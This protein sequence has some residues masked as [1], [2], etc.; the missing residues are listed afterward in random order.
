MILRRTADNLAAILAQLG[1]DVDP[2]ML[3]DV[4]R[5]RIAHGHNPLP[6]DA[7]RALALLADSLI[8]EQQ[9]DGRAR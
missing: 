4:W 1:A 6:A 7:L 2:V 3:A 8:I 5:D 9:A